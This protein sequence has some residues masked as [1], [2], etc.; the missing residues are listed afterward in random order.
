MTAIQFI[1]TTRLIFSIW[2]L[3]MGLLFALIWHTSRVSMIGKQ[4]TLLSRAQHS[5]TGGLVIVSFGVSTSYLF[6][7]IGNLPGDEMIDPIPARIAAQV[8][9]LI[10]LVV[11]T[12]AG[13]YVARSLLERWRHK[14][15]GMGIS[16][17]RILATV[18][19][20]LPMVVSDQGGVIRYV[21]EPMEELALAKPGEL[22]GLNTTEIM[23]ERYRAHH[24]AGV[25][26]Y[27]KT[28]E[29]RLIGK[30]VNVDLL[31][32]DGT[33]IPISLAFTASRAE[34]HD[35]FIAIIWARETYDQPR[36]EA[37]NIR[38]DDREVH[39]NEEGVSLD[40]RRSQQDQREGRQVA[41]EERLTKQGEEQDQREIR[42]DT[43]DDER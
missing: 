31:R 25:E 24:I 11:T 4:R 10:G 17:E 39:Q 28:G 2:F 19:V 14:Q 23:P 43:R 13:V 42:Q 29:A 8:I 1:E 7:R 16:Q 33:E 32:R 37:V 38:Q 22:D 5:L 27:V 20:D 18:A 30:V 9:L 21:T 15:S 12:W 35:W 26:R 34:E 3:G 36:M 41:T 40:A 6:R